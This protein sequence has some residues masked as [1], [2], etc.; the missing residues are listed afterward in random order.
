MAYTIG[1]F[2]SPSAA[3]GSRR[4][5]TP[6]T[7]IKKSVSYVAGGADSNLVISISGTDAADAIKSAI[8]SAVEVKNTGVVPTIVISQYEGYSDEDTDAGRY[9]IQTMLMPNETFSPP[10]RGIIPTA[11]QLQVLDGTVID[12]TSTIGDTSNTFADFESDS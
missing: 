5:K 9:T 10:V 11:N 7:S 8:P 4:S 12:F 3:R 2:K 6:T 1:T